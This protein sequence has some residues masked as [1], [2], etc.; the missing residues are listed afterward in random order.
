MLARMEG[1]ATEKQ[2]LRPLR[3]ALTRAV[4]RAWVTKIPGLLPELEAALQAAGG[5][6]E[7][8]KMSKTPAGERAGR[9][10]LPGVCKNYLRK[11]GPDHAVSGHLRKIRNLIGE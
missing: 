8:V 11:L 4:R 6:I 7:D 1:N 2:A 5:P 10:K 3:E 9:Q